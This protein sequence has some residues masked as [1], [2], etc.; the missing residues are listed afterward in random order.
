MNTQSQ[1]L[2][3]LLTNEPQSKWELADKLGCGERQ[4]R[5]CIS[6]LRKSGFN[7]AA[8]SDGEGYWRGSDSDRRRTVKELRSRAYKLIETANALEKGPDLG[9]MEVEV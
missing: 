1:E 7:V 9:Q 6:E 4:V 8:N 5:R 3:S 2:W